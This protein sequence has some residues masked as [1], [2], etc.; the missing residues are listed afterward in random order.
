MELRLDVA[1]ADT[2]PGQFVLG[3]LD[4]TSTPL[5]SPPRKRVVDLAEPKLLRGTAERRLTAGGTSREQGEGLGRKGHGLVVL[6][7]RDQTHRVGV[8]VQ[9]QL[10]GLGDRGI[11]VFQ[12]A[13]P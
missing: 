4:Q 9:M 11:M 12:L 1:L 10:G 3:Q 7:V 13:E 8:Q 6:L 5:G 2:A